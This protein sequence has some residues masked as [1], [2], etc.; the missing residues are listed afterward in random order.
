MF[1]VLLNHPDPTIQTVPLLDKGTDNLALYSSSDKACK[2][3]QDSHLGSEFGYSVFGFHAGVGCP[4]TMKKKGLTKDEALKEFEE[5]IGTIN[6]LVIA[7]GIPADT[8]S[9]V[10][11]VKTILPGTRERLAKAY[12]AL[13][14]SYI[15]K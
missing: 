6:N 4:A 1:F 12:S 5:C 15:W 7:M 11:V 8:E 9:H 2:D 14:G 13:G 10:N 3:A